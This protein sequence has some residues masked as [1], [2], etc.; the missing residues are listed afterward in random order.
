MTVIEAPPRG[1]IRG[2]EAPDPRAT[3]L[4]RWST[5]ALTIIPLAGVV[6]AVVLL[7][8]TGISAVDATIALAAYVITGLGIT[9]GYHRYFTHK[10]FNAPRPVRAALAVAGSL[11]IQGS[12]IDWVA[13]HRR[14]HAFSDQFGD[15]HSPHV[16]VDDGVRGV[17]R[18]LYHAHIGWLFEPS[19]TV[20]EVWAPDLLDDDL[21][22]RIDRAFPWMILVSF[23]LPAVI[24]GL[25]TWS[26]TGAL[27]AF[28]WG[29]L[30]RIFVLHHVTWSINSI[31]HF[32][33]SRPYE[34]RDEARNNV[35][36][37]LLG[38]GEGWHNAHHAF[39]ASARHG[40]RWWEFDA[41]WITIRALQVLG[42]VS[43]VKLPSERQLARRARAE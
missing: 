38:F 1:A 20:A 4:Q 8:G 12:V 30:V 37:A 23:A 41:S 7:W 28:V 26:I 21:I 43:D 18:G 14:H 15:P 17:L 36:M 31:C 11:A 32:Y 2:V 39:P 40:M 29:S 34:S 19:G 24:G 27:T 16:D 13:T 6:T 42:L 22:R 5:L 33:G 35:F 3:R 10:S 9:V 25:V